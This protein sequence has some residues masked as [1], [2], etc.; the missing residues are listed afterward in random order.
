MFYDSIIIIKVE[1]IVEIRTKIDGIPA[2]IR[3][4]DRNDLYYIENTRI[5]CGSKLDLSAF[6]QEQY[7]VL[8]N[9]VQKG[10]YTLRFFETGVLYFKAGK[11]KMRGNS[12]S[13]GQ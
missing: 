10:S 6:I 7:R 9:E 5:F 4:R 12:I 2:F 8:F 13:I 3:D 1:S 11:E